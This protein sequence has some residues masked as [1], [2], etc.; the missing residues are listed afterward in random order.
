MLYTKTREQIEKL[1]S[2]GRLRKQ[3]T[4]LAYPRKHTIRNAQLAEFELQIRGKVVYPWSKGYNQDRVD[5]NNVYPVYPKMIVYPICLEDIRKTLVF[6]QE[7]KYWM[8]VRSGGHSLA[9][10]SVCDGIVLDMSSF[11]SIVI[12]P[13]DKTALIECGCTFGDIYPRVESYGLHLP[14]GGCPT[15]AIAGFMQGGG[16]SLTSRNFGINCDCVLE[17]T[18]MLA[19][20]QIVVA[21]KSQNKD[22][23]WAMRG[24]TGNNFGILL[25][26]KYQLFPLKDIYGMQ[27]TWNID[28]N[29]DNAALALY[30]IQ[31]KYLKGYSY[32]NLGIETVLTSDPKGKYKNV[33]F[34]G[35]WIGEKEAMDIALQPLLDIPGAVITINEKGPYSKINNDLLESCPVLPDDV[36]AYSQSVYIEKSLTVNDWK[37]ILKFFQTAPNKY[38][39]VDME[40]YG[41][42]IGTI[43]PSECAFIHR[44]V[45]MDF[46]CDAFFDAK[47][48]DQ[49]KNEEWLAAFM[50]FMK[51]YG[52]GHSYQNYP[53]RKATNYKWE[54][55][56]EYYNL[57]VLIKNKYDKNNFFHYMQ[58]IGKPIGTR[59]EKKQILL[60]D[61]NTPIKYEDY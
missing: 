20:G 29:F 27:I 34:C 61:T 25:S 22:L 38:T 58:S 44:K 5:F 51:K 31:E 23:F 26:V 47:T 35:A 56:G 42:K 41:G 50:D 39:M 3:H 9:G 19:D 15:V 48:N 11:K 55:W 10:F 12:N 14:G 24:G 40:G 1:K 32:P 37:N 7:Q 30:T 18:V 17:I 46:F 45:T 6:A 33:Y 59:Y 54:Y 49:K 2:V 36:K 52:N 13:A 53:N 4:K 21:N 28:T 60:F 57:L 43:D 8:V 16:Y